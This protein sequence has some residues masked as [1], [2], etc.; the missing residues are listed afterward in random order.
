MLV[1]G[2]AVATSPAK[3]HGPKKVAPGSRVGEGVRGKGAFSTLHIRTAAGSIEEC[4]HYIGLGFDLGAM[5]PMCDGYGILHYAAKFNRVDVIELAVNR[6]ADPL[7]EDWNGVRPHEIAR[8]KGN[9]AALAA[10]QK[11]IQHVNNRTV[12]ATSPLPAFA[13]SSNRSPNKAASPSSALLATSPKYAARRAMD[14]GFEVDQDGDGQLD[15]YERQAAGLD[16]G[17]LDQDGDGKISTQEAE[18]F[19]ELTRDL[20]EWL[21]QMNLAYYFKD[22]TDQGIYTLQDLTDANLCEDDLEDDFGV[23]SDRERMKVLKAIAQI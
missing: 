1:P 2:N 18:D 13:V 11:S 4:R 3:A 8:Q 7:M 21:S 17:V 20:Q 16:R 9:Y 6:G 22:F 19:A 23:A 10:L 15:E 12:P 5:D 14:V